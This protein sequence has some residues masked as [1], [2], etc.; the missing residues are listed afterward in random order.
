MRI[1]LLRT[2]TT[3]I[4]NGF[5]DYGA[6]AMLER[7][8]PDAEI[9]ETGGYP[10]H[11]AD[12]AAL[13]R[14]TRKFERMAGHGADYESP[15]HQIRQNV[16]NVSE[17]IDADL[18]VL[19]GCVLSRPTFRKYFDTLTRLRERDIPIVIVGGGGEEYDE[20]ERKDVEAVFDAL[21]IEVLLTRDRTAYEEYGDLV[22]YLYDGIDCS[23]FLGDA[24]QP[25]EANQEFDVHTF[26]KGG[27][28]DIDG[29][30]ST[31]IRPDHAPFDEPY[32]FP[33]GERARELLGL[34]TPLFEAENV[35]VSDMVTDYLF[36]YANAD[37]VRSDR[38]H[39]C[40][41][42]LTYG[43]RAQFYFDTPRANLFDRVPIDGDVTSEPVRFDMDELERE[44]DAQVEAL[45]EG[46]TTVL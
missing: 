43:N 18:A 35:F 45:E 13:W 8:F 9:V 25:P 16:V 40:L 3:N 27:E 19:P 15:T 22:E 4:G 14:G 29:A 39:A 37:V 11:A 31:I 20:A 5:I 23:L 2:W 12:T 38:I 17:L 46:V 21:D 42:A 7:A 28:P 33:V 36:L 44:K 24:H 30:S 32:H 26:D 6:K 1:L 10:N 41:P 34:E